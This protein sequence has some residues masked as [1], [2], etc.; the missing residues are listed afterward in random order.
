MSAA[1]SPSEASTLSAVS[2]ARVRVDGGFALTLAERDGHSIVRDLRESD[3][4]RV[5]FPRSHGD[6]PEAVVINTGGGLVGGD[7]I[8]QSV[9]I[10]AGATGVVTTQAAERVYRALGGARTQI[11]VDI[12][13]AHRGL[14]H[15]LPQET[16]VFDRARL[17]RRLGIDVAG[18]G[19]CVA[20]ESVVLGRQAMGESVRTGLY[21][22]TWRARVDG[23]LVF[24]ENVVLDGDIEAIMCSAACGQG[25]RVLTTMIA[26]GPGMPER[27]ERV[28][29]A[30]A[31]TPCLAAASAWG[32]MLVL[33]GLG[34]TSHE[35][36]ALVMRAL[37]E[38]TDRPLPRVW[39]L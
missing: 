13:V 32:P 11:A 31:G 28:R 10:E 14:L 18:D 20:M 22:D 34:T 16:I 2:L 36:R 19:C 24:A 37:P 3:G 26:I 15:W 39:S 6:G 12:T 29:G 33:R 27:I 17:E 21:R 8:R 4:Y 23:R 9:T 7:R 30:I 1:V 35:V 5:R 25:A 38:L